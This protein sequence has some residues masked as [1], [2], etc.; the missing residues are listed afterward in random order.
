MQAWSLSSQPGVRSSPATGQDRVAAGFS[1]LWNMGQW[2][3][4]GTGTLSTPMRPCWLWDPL[5]DCHNSPVMLMGEHPGL[6]GAAWPAL[7]FC[8]LSSPLC[9]FPVLLPL[10]EG[11]TTVTFLRSSADALTCLFL[12]ET[13]RRLVYFRGESADLSPLGCTW[14][15]G[16]GRGCQPGLLSMI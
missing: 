13:S 7:K 16:W 8:C 5:G 1:V 10:S 3:E 11:R 15:L 9:Y 4:E 2:G 12:L 6:R 14:F